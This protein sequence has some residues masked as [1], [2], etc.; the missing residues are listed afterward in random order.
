M[1][2]EVLSLVQY[3]WKA[4]YFCLNNFY[5]LKKY[6]N[7]SLFPTK[8]PPVGCCPPRISWKWVKRKVCPSWRCRPPLVI[9]CPFHLQTPLHVKLLLLLHIATLLLANPS[10]PSSPL[11][12]RSDSCS[13]AM[14]RNNIV[15]VRVVV[16]LEAW[17]SQGKQGI[18]QR[19]TPGKWINNDSQKT[20]CSHL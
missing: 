9:P 13:S 4:N 17:L 10:P 6:C 15:V 18:L 1:L 19:S 7:S 2:K 3:I 20:I 16:T 8:P 12:A 5:L 11:L 14:W